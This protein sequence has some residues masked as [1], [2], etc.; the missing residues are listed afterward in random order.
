MKKQES[1]DKEKKFDKLVNTVEETQ[2][3]VKDFSHC[4]NDYQSVGC[5]L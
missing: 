2:E 4:V 1:K 5:N 3:L